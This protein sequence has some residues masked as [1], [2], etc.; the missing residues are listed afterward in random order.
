M[1]A[2]TVQLERADITRIDVRQAK[3]AWQEFR[4][5]QGAWADR[6]VPLLTAPDAN[7]KLA[8][9]DIPTWGLSLAPAG[10]AGVGT[11]CMWS[12]PLCRKGCLNTA[13]KGTLDR[14][15][16]GRVLKTQFLAANPS[17]FITLLEFEIRRARL[18]TSVTD[19]MLVR[20][21]VLSDLRWERFA[22]HLFDIEGV[23]F[24]D[25]TKS[26][27]R[28][29]AQGAPWWPKNYKLVFSASER[30]PDVDVHRMLNLNLTVAMVFDEIPARW[31]G[32]DVVNGDLTDDRYHEPQG[33]LVGLRAKGKMRQHRAAYA[34]FVRSAQGAYA[35]A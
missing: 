30:N 17:A 4:Q 10:L 6:Y 22:P 21:N 31:D 8:K 32:W 26:V 27:E 25:Y 20:L 34:G 29:M 28:A 35:A 9:S 13:G 5:A 3:Q 1:S 16:R 14:V 23:E 18:A 2:L 19:Q 7:V 12:T 11:T 24:Y 15:Q 33:V